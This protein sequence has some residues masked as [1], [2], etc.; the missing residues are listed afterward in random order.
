MKYLISLC[1]ILLI[2]SI[3]FAS[4]NK[5]SAFVSYYLQRTEINIKDTTPKVTTTCEIIFKFNDEKS[6]SLYHD[7]SVY[8]SSFE[9]L[10]D[11]E[12]FTKNPQPNGKMKTIEI[13]DFKMNNAKS[14]SVF[15]DDEKEINITFLGL[16][17]GSEAHVKYTTST[18]EAHFTDPFSFSF[19][20]PVQE[21]RY[22]LI[23]PEEVTI[24][25]IEKNIL[26]TTFKFEKEVKRNETIYTWTAKDIEEQKPIDNPP[27]RM[28][29]TPHVLYKID[30]YRARGK[31]FTVS[32][33][34]R[35]LF[36]WYVKNIK[37]VNKKP[38]DRIQA[39]ADSIVKGCTNDR[40]KVIR[41]YDWVKQ[42]IRYVAFEN[43]MEGIIP[44]EADLVCAR[45]YG[46]CKDMSSLQFALLRAVKV[47]AYLTWLGTRRIPYTYSEV[48]LKNTDN[49]M[50]ASVNLDGK[51]Y[52]L[53]ATDPNGFYDLPSDHIQGKQVMIYKNDTEYEL[54]MVPVVKAEKN[55]FQEVNKIRLDK[56]KATIT[57]ETKYTGLLANNI[58][59]QLLYVSENDRQ[60]FG[61][62]I[63]KSISNNAALEKFVVEKATPNREVNYR[64]DFS[65]ADF[66]KEVDDE[67]YVN[68][69]MDRTL[70]NSYIKEPNRTIPYSFQYNSM[71]EITYQLSVPEN[72]KVAYLPEN[73]DLKQDGFGASIN[74]SQSGQDI[75]CKQRIYLD[76]TELELKPAQ[77]ES[78]NKFIKQ[79]NKAYKESIT[80]KKL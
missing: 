6:I 23:V 22:E 26:P 45:R 75:I 11:I 10:D 31:V 55:M 5:S 74:Y 28:A 21:R 58:S 68:V 17:V 62:G 46:D 73:V 76:L 50:I 78:W 25:L 54:V 38:S 69:L 66:A 42:N 67:I 77:F 61:K 59:N 79:L 18:Q 44:R 60:E 4:I 36:N 52:F 71:H 51:W 37:H 47:P 56:T 2:N 43:G 19:Y 70:S 13:K 35:D 1:F 30:E 12:V 33:T 39:L 40:E 24:S 48:P 64:V 15:Y 80:F 3:T 32:K 41:I 8:I 65:I 16:T 29:Y 14:N 72:Y 63:I 53:D 57:T 27:A 20:M 49:H 34:P 9:K 7:Y